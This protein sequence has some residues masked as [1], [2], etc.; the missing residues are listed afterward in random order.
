ML[1]WLGERM[2]KNTFLFI[3]VQVQKNCSCGQKLLH[4]CIHT[5]VQRSQLSSFLDSFIIIY[6]NTTY[7][8][9]C[10]WTWRAIRIWICIILSLKTRS[11][12]YVFL[13]LSVWDYFSKHDD[14]ARAYGFLFLYICNIVIYRR[15][16]EYAIFGP[17][18]TQCTSNP[19]TSRLMLF[20]VGS[21]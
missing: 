14:W 12:A 6:T 1:W 8:V 10:I 2:S 15:Y 20:S 7:V 3:L 11:G 4:I 13:L 21:F 5:E 17:K 19:R 16:S 18:K 9:G